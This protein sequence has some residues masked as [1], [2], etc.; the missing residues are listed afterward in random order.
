MKKTF[1]FC[2]AVVA[3]F[4]LGVAPAFADTTLDTA[5]ASVSTQIQGVQGSIL[6]YVPTVIGYGLV[7]GALILGAMVGWHAFRRFV[8]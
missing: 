2:V 5:F 7:I 4:A 6:T 8:H 1:A 3:L